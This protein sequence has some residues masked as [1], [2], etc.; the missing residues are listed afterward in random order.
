MTK[1]GE[2]IGTYYY[3]VEKKKWELIH[4]VDNIEYAKQLE[5][6][7]KELSNQKQQFE[8]QKNEEVEI[9]TTATAQKI[10]LEEQYEKVY[11]ASID[12][13]KKGL[14]ELIAKTQQLIDKRREYLSM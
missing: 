7:F 8:A 4:N 6:Q 3:D 14:D 5:Q 1:N 13:Q 11:Q 2:E 10:Q 9:L 12:K